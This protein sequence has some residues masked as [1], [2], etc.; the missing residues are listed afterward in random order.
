MGLLTAGSSDLRGDGVIKLRGPDH[1]YWL[2]AGSWALRPANTE[3]DP[4]GPGAD[5]GNLF[6]AFL[7]SYFT[8]WETGPN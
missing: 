3:P 2:A 7:V 5:S 4:R 1:L 8:G 6:V